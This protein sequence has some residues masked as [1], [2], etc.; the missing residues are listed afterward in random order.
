MHPMKIHCVGAHLPVYVTRLKNA[1]IPVLKLGE[2][3]RKT[4]VQRASSVQ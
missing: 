3:V 4:K 2:I 1:Q